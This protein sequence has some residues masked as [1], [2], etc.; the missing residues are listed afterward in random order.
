METALNR[1]IRLLQLSP[2]GNGLFQGENQDL[3]LPQLFGGQLVA[4]SLVAAMQIVPRERRL[5]SCHSQ[6]IQAG[7]VDIP[8]IYETELVREGGSFTLV[9]VKAKQQD[10]LILQLTASFQIEETG[11]E[12][13][14]AA[15]QVG[16]PDSLY[17][18][19]EL[20]KPMA[21]KMPKALRDF[22]VQEKP[23]DVRAKWVNNPFK[24]Q[25]LPE[26]QMLWVK[27][28]GV[29]PIDVRLQQCLLAYF[30]DFHCIP[31]ILH[32]HQC[33]VFEQK[34]RFATLDHAIWFHRDF[35]FNQ[36]LL[37]TL[38][39]S[40]SSGARGLV[41]GRVFDQAGRL[42]VEYRQEALIRPIG[43]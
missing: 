26:E 43:E 40:S 28:R 9:N 18:E 29:A 30:S 7:R 32:P 23:F 1:L 25:Q 38:Q 39:T 11:F 24:G 41:S 5:H 22:F 33:G 12:F 14:L 15:P 13:Q 37:F 17:D 8:V 34:C 36:W 4:Q 3:G 42:L 6:F 21:E 35:D 31:T 2:L 10:M 27:T 16:E 20:F 19:V